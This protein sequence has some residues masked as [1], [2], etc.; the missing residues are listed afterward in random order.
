MDKKSNIKLFERIKY[1]NNIEIYFVVIIGLIL[2][3]TYFSSSGIDANTSL[4][5]EEK[6]LCEVLSKIKGAGEV[7]LIITRNREDQVVGV[8]VV[9]TGGKDVGVK[10][11][12]IN[13][14]ARAL[15]VDSTKIEVFE[16]K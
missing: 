6:R 1:V 3:L 5:E 15:N 16:R 4:N 10:V 14:C 13:A 2:L 9:A 11:R 7:S 12:I 8:V